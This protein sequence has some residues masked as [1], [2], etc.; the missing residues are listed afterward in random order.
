[1]LLTNRVHPDDTDDRIR[2]LRPTFHDAVWAT[3]D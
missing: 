1:V 2:T 3:V